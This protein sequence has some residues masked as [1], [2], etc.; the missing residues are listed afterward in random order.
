MV[1]QKSRKQPNNQI[2][3]NVAHFVDKITWNLQKGA[4]DLN[5][6]KSIT[7]IGVFQQVAPYVKEYAFEFLAYLIYITNAWLPTDVAFESSRIQ[8]Q[9]GEYIRNT[10]MLKRLFEHDENFGVRNEMRIHNQRAIHDALK[11]EFPEIDD[12]TDELQK[13]TLEDFITAYI[14]GNLFFHD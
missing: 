6:Y 12:L 5:T 4:M 9:V 14:T 2:A 11:K 13:L 8:H 7:E 10:I 3:H 1:L